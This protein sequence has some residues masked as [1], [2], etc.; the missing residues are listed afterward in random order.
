M[1]CMAAFCDILSELRKSLRLSQKDLADLLHVSTSTISNYETNR[2]AP[3]IENLLWLAD[4]FGVTTDYLLGR[5]SIN[6]PA[7]ELEQIYANGQTVGDVLKLLLS[8]QGHSR[9]IAVYI[10]QS[11]QLSDIAEQ[12]RS[13]NEEH[14]T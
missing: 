11:I 2:N 13:Q 5:S 14:K 9:N 12:Q 4:Y 1:F 8:L 10:L 6:L 7:S 3:D